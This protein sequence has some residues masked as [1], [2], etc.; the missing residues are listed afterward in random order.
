ML[1]YMMPP[2]P[3]VVDELLQGMVRFDSV[4][5]AI[6]GREMPEQA[7]AVW[8]EHLAT[9]WG[10]QTRWLPWALTDAKRQETGG[11]LPRPGDQLLITVFADDSQGAAAARP[12]L[13]FDSHLDTVAVEGMTIDPFGAVIDGDRLLG[14]GSCDTKGTGAAMLWALKEYAAG[15]RRPN[16]VA[17]LF[18]VDEEY[19]M[20]G[21]ASFIEHHLPSIGFAP[22]GVIVG[23]PTMMRPVVAHN[24]VTRWRVSTTGVAAHSAASYLGRSAIRMMAKVMHAIE[25]DY[26]ARLD[27]P[28]L[29][30]GG[31]V[32]NITTISG[33]SQ[34]NIIPEH[35]VIE[36][37]R[38]LAPGETAEAA[39]VVLQGVLDVL[40]AAEP[41][42]VV[43]LEMFRDAP[44]LLEQ[45]SA[46]IL[47]RVQR[48]LANNGMP[49]NAIGA[50]FATH[51][52]DLAA[53]GLPALVWGPGEPYPAHTKDE[54]VSLK[55]IRKGADVY[56][57]LMMD[58]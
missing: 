39:T 31:A 54:Y 23:E 47:P 14:R 30:T 46:A 13:L 10:M 36:I 17:L 24:G 33:G 53:A 18:S 4:N 11:Q 26:I 48:V 42:L 57:Q 9:S 58:A 51:A 21:I 7:L 28:H 40:V 32:C 50:P 6:S 41:E 27:A 52:G 5:A 55:D 15:E 16:N 8:L 1:F 20:T 29:L 12:W 38:R 35:C 34:V 49:K 22:I 37:D 44:P 43:K 2:F 19:A 3:Q 45:A 56:R 25:T